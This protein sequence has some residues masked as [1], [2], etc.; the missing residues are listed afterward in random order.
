MLAY[1]AA[2][3]SVCLGDG[4]ALSTRSAIPIVIDCPNQQGQ[5]DVNL[6]TILKFIGKDLKVEGQVLVTFEADVQQPFDKK[7]TLVG[8]RSLLR[9][10]EFN[11]VNTAVDPL[12]AKM[13]E[14]LLTQ[15]VG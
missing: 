4:S 8:E 6:P 11:A 2:L 3:W 5:D 12:L 7:I 14:A 9:E 10:D 13:Y 15:T 1:Y